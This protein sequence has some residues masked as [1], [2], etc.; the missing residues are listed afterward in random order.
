MAEGGVRP[1]VT[2]RMGSLLA[3]RHHAD[4]VPPPVSCV[5][6]VPPPGLVPRKTAVRSGAS[7]ASRHD[8]SSKTDLTGPDIVRRI[9][10]LVL[11]LLRVPAVSSRPTPGSVPLCRCLFP[12]N[13]LDHQIRDT[14]DTSGTYSVRGIRPLADMCSRTVS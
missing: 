14:S 4:P 7:W 12:C 6:V 8:P 10:P 11:V 13:A 2:E 9:R 1:C 5:V 3:V